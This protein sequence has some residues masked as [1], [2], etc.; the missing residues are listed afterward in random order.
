MTDDSAVVLCHNLNP[1]AF[2]WLWM[3]YVRGV[4]DQHHC[5]NCLRGWYG[6]RLNKA[7]RSLL[8]TP[9]LV[10]DERP[11]SSFHAIYICG[12]YKQGYPKSNYPHNLHAAVL[13]RQ[14]AED[15]FQFENWT[16]DVRNG[17]FLTIPLESELP[18]RYRSLPPEFTSC[19]IFRWAVS[20][21][22]NEVCVGHG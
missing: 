13:P 8:A 4:N 6:N 15:R 3:K 7:N 20:S 9:D 10:L 19:R 2:M 17:I 21:F 16:L 12:V 14:G 22:L 1:D 11:L 5:T 18:T